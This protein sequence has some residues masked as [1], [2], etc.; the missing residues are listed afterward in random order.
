MDWIYDALKSEFLWG[1][2]LGVLLAALTTTIGIFTQRRFNERI[3]KR[4]CKDLTNNI[5]EI[6]EQLQDTRARSNFI[7]HEF[8][9]LIEVE[10]AVFGRVRE[11]I[12]AVTDDSLRKDI[13]RF[14]TK[15][16]VQ[17]TR[18]RTHLRHFQEKYSQQNPLDSG[19]EMELLVAQVEQHLRDA[20]MQCDALQE[21]VKS[22][23]NELLRKLI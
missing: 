1:T 9:D 15:T 16:S 19:P 18:V 10:V 7:D 3:I 2:V 20:Q 13:R 5:L 21:H 17:Y 8:I 11:H 22:K 4:L 14:F 6:A 23:G 12:S